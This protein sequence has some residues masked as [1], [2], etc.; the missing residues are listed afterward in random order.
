VSAIARLASLTRTPVP[1]W[2]EYDYE[3]TPDNIDLVIADIRKR[4][5]FADNTFDVVHMRQMRL[6][7]RISPTSEPSLHSP[8]IQ[9]T[10]FTALVDEAAR[11]LRPGGLLLSGEWG[12]WTLIDTVGLEPDVYA[13][14]YTRFSNMLG[15]VIERNGPYATAEGIV[16]LIE[17]TG[18]FS[19]KEDRAFIVRVSHFSAS[20]PRILMH[21][22]PASSPSAKRSTRNVTPTS[23][24]D[25]RSRLLHTA[26]ASATS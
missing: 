20:L 18:H 24:G 16:G 23:G 14:S 6:V 3:D 22:D 17:R 2:E 11:I 4:T 15:D 25:W 10:D 13:P 7:V 21:D 1:V 9:S 5:P 8:K 26:G 19:R 12:R